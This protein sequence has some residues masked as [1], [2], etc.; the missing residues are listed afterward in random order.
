MFL[1]APDARRRS[2]RRGQAGI[3]RW[4]LRTRRPDRGI[5]LGGPVPG[6]KP[7]PALASGRA[8]GG[9]ALSC[10]QVSPAPVEQVSPP[11][12]ELFVDSGSLP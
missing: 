9:A 6:G 5:T 4:Q 2:L 3:G 7:S 10:C 11:G 1:R 12:S 8:E